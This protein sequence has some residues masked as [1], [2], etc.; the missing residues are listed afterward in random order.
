MALSLR[1]TKNVIE[2][3]ERNLG[4]C[5]SIYG[6]PVIGGRLDSGP[7]GN[8]CRY[9]FGNGGSYLYQY[10]DGIW[11]RLSMVDPYVRDVTLDWNGNLVLGTDDGIYLWNGGE[12]TTYRCP[13][14]LF[15]RGYYFV[16]GLEGDVWFY[17][18]RTGSPLIRHWDYDFIA[19]TP[20]NDGISDDIFSWYR[21]G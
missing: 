8:C 14:R 7:D 10:R 13:S 5:H 15:Y 9:A 12:F 20:E 3:Q 1:T 18:S 11:S 19:Y 21:A 17:G 2:F 16:A 6:Q 4:E